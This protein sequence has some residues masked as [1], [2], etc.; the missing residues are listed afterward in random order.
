MSQWGCSVH[1]HQAPPAQGESRG[2]RGEPQL[3][4]NQREPGANPAIRRLGHPTY[5]GD[6]PPFPSP[7]PPEGGGGSMTPG[8]FREPRAPSPCKPRPAADRPTVPASR[9]SGV[10]M[11]PSL[12]G[13]PGWGRAGPG[14]RGWGR[15]H[16][17][18]GSA[19]R[20]GSGS[21]GLRRRWARP[22]A[23]PPHGAPRQPVS[24]AS[25]VR[26]GRP[27]LGLGRPELRVA[28]VAQR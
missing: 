24:H 3:R 26:A 22:A 8:R 7:C 28:R 27:G 6:A 23:L 19:T 15:S 1:S 20:P 14:S 4:H 12:D 2:I 18:A 11:A 25:R 17:P 9:V 13:R 16:S 21:G 5:G 10:S